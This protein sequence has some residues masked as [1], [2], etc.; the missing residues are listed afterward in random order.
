[1]ELEDEHVGR[2]GAEIASGSVQR[3]ASSLVASATRGGDPR[4]PGGQSVGRRRLWLAAV[5]AVAAFVVSTVLAN[6]DDT[7]AF[8]SK[9]RSWARRAAIGW[10]AVPRPTRCSDS[11]D[12]DLRGGA[13]G[14]LIDGGNRQDVIDAGPGDDRIRAYDGWLDTVRCG[15][16]DDVAFVDPVDMAAGCEELREYPTTVRDHRAVLLPGS[17]SQPSAS[18]PVRG[19][20]SSTS[21]RTSAADRSISMSSR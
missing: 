6:R 19:E 9:G 17:V 5:G 2:Q 13:G 16:G 21:K 15:A 11:G 3:P 4:E 1:M 7:S 20:S 8:D 12:D 10:P 14:D 18:F